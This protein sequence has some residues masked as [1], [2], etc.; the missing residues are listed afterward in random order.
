MD[1][2]ESA[3]TMAN[4]LTALM[5]NKTAYLEYFKWRRDGWVRAYQNTGYRFVFH[6]VETRSLRDIMNINFTSSFKSL[7]FPEIGNAFRF[8][9]CKLCEALLEERP[10]KTYENVEEWFH[11]TS[12][13]EGSEFAEGWK[14]E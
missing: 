1:D 10:T 12:E 11:G 8:H 4:Y 6:S 13:C 9:F 5:S 14:E 7:M 2:F 3:Q